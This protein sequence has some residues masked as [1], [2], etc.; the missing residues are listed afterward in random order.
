M[1]EYRHSF[2]MHK[3]RDVFGICPY[4]ALEGLA[5]DEYYDEEG[6]FIGKK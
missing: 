5:P 1:I 6:N 4:Y 3:T 2:G